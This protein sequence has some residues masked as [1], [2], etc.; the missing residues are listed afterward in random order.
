[1]HTRRRKRTANGVMSSV[2]NFFK[3]SE[4]TKPVALCQC[5]MG[6]TGGRGEQCL[7]PAVRDTVFCAKHQN[8]AAGSPRS[9]A[10]PAFQPQRYNRDPAIYKSHNCYSYSMNVVDGDLVVKCRETGNCRR[11]F[12][13]PG[14]KSG[15]RN[16]LDAA[17]RRT[18]AVVEKLQKSDIPEIEKTDFTSRCPVGMSKIA[19]VVDPGEDYHYY[20]QDDDG[21]WSHKDGSNKVKRVDAVG[22]G[23]WD[24]RYISRDYRWKGSDLNY[25]SFCGF[26]CVP[27]DHEIRLGKGGG[28]V[29]GAWM[30]RRRQSQRRQT[31]RR[32]SRRR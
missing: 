8:C 1:M 6:G 14:A 2:M 11:Y 31:R 28:G 4:T 19:L 25:E 7:E 22:K 17:S 15:D 12:H 10:E 26:Y 18:C 29:G 30:T 21:W 23:I 5:S 9:G 20:R 13:Q 16:A 3:P 27:R 32:L 24:P